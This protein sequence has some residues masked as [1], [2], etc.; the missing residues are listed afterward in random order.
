MFHADITFTLA[1]IAL[2]FAT[3]ILMKAKKFAELGVSG[4]KFFGYVVAVLAIIMLIFSGYS[5]VRQS[6]FMCKLH[7]RMSRMMH[8]KMMKRRHYP[9][10]RVM[11]RRKDQFMRDQNNMNARRMHRREMRMMNKEARPMPPR[12]GAVMR[13]A[14]AHMQKVMN[15]QTAKTPPPV[16]QN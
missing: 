15:A 13:P 7:S 14:N 3:M 10:V 6:I 16:P 5:T 9:M 2:A 12:D 4:C 8:R 1:L 11:V